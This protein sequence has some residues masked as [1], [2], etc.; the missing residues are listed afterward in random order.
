[1]CDA[2]K[3]YAKEYAE[4]YAKE[5]TLE[6]VKNLMRSAHVSLDQA[7]QM[8]GFKDSTRDYVVSRLQK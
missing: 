6:N 8:L 3:E 4:E 5:S 1:M 7:I 2:V